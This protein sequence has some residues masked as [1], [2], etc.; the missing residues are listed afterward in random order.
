MNNSFKQNKLAST[1]SKLPSDYVENS[2][3]P[4]ETIVINKRSEEAMQVTTNYMSALRTETTESVIFSV[5]VGMDQK[6]DEI[7][8]LNAVIED[9]PIMTF[10]SSES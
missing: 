5:N 2:R 6:A 9:E 1:A 7:K 10:V 3:N 8:K 4:N